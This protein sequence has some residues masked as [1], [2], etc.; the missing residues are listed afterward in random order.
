[1]QKARALVFVLAAMVMSVGIAEGMTITE[2]KIAQAIPVTLSYASGSGELTYDENVGAQ[3]Q[4]TFKDTDDN[5]SIEIF[6][7]VNISSAHTLTAD[8]SNG[9]QA[10]GEFD[11]GSI[12]VQISGPLGINPGSDVTSITLAGYFDGDMDWFELQANNGL[13][14]PTLNGTGVFT[15]TTNNVVS[16]SGIIW[17]ATWILGAVRSVIITTHHSLVPASPADLSGDISSTSGSLVVWAYPFVPEPL[18]LALLG[19]GGVAVLRRRR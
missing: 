19:L 6:T 13:P 1:M 18:T 7:S 17:D 9:G 3:A 14:N 11:T 4:V 15:L 16:N 10:S 8:N 12:S 5:T 2:V